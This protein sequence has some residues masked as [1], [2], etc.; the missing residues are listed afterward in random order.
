MN[1]PPSDE[2]ESSIDIFVLSKNQTEVPAR[3][4]PLEQMGYRITLFDDPPA[5][6]E[7]LHEGK[8]NL[9]ICDTLSFPEAYDL[10]RHVKDDTDLWVIPVLILTS[11]SDLSDLLHVLDCNADNYIAY[12]YDPG[13]FQSLIE[14]MLSTPVERQTP[15]QIKTQFKIQHDDRIFVVTADRR[16][17]LEFLL[18]SFE[19]AVSKIHD[20]SRTNG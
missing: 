3:M 10:C 6:I 16:K 9:L 1:A 14:G 20:L 15:D 13:Y 12:P 17:L 19:I 4:A 5:L 11:A 2:S 18:S 8:P 7:S